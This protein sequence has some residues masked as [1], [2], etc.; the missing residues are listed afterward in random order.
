[1]DFTI[2]KSKLCDLLRGLGASSGSLGGGR[3]SSG[4]SRGLMVSLRSSSMFLSSSFLGRGGP[5]SSRV[6]GRRGCESRSSSSLLSMSSIRAR[7]AR[8]YAVSFTNLA[9]D[10][11]SYACLLCSIRFS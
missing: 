7:L 4:S 9:T 1:M 8:L 2:C 11:G 6:H 10:N 3:D 5:S